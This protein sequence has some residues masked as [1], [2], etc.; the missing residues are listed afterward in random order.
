MEKY[1]IKNISKGTFISDET[2]GKVKHT[3][4]EINAVVFF[5]EMEA[6]TV[7]EFLNDTYSDCYTLIDLNN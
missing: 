3:R 4:K 1:I 2:N 5:D 6:E 7:L